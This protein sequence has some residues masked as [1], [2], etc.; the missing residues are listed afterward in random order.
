MQFIDIHTHFIPGIDD[1]ATSIQETVEML[2]VAYAAGTRGLVATPH[3]FL[4]GYEK[5][6]ILLVNDRFAATL[7]ALKEYSE[8]PEYAFIREMRLSLG[9]ENYASIE[10]IDAL[11]RGCAV[12]INGGRYLLVEFSP[13]LPLAKIEMILQRV[14]QF[15]YFPVVAHTERITAIQEKPARLEDLAAMGCLFQVNG[16]SFLDSANPRLRKTSMTLAKS[17]FIHVI[18]S[19]GHRP[20][21]RPP[22]LSG[23]SQELLRKFSVQVV[24]T[25]LHDNPARIVDNLEI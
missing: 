24:Q 16:D 1:G 15:G 21:R 2:Q 13:F 23:A 9:S 10:F 4:D 18:A 11:A 19:D 22:V 6:D 17:G 7:A 20:S 8:K 12:P 14:H 25:W 5:N 3:M